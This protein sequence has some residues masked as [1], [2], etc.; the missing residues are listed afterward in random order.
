M[1]F[2]PISRREFFYSVGAGALAAYSPAQPAGESLWS[3]PVRGSW[4]RRGGS[5]NGDVLLA[6]PGSG[7][8][9]VVG[10]GEHTAVK[11][12]ASFLAADVKKIS[13]YTPP[14]VARAGGDRPAIYLTTLGAQRLPAGIQRTRLEGQWEAYQVLTS[15][16]DVWIVGSNFRGTAF[17]AYTLSERL[18]IDPLYHWTGYTPEKHLPLALKKTDFFAGPPT[19]KYRGLFHDDEDILPRPFDNDGYPLQTGTV[20]RVWYERYFETALRL[21]LNQVAPYTR[22]RRRFEVQ[23]MAGDWGL[24]YSSHHYDALLSN[25]FGFERFGL[26]AERKAGDRWDWY[27]NREGLENFW[28]GGVLENRDLD[29]IWPL[30]LRGTEDRSYTFPPGATE[31]ERLRVFQQVLDTQVRL[32]EQ[33]LPPG[34][35]PIFHFTVYGEMLN[36]YLSG[37]LKV[38]EQA[39]L[40]WTDN[41]DGTMRGLPAKA[42]AG[43]H[44]VYYHLA[45]YGGSTKQSAHTVTPERIA[46]EFRN[47]VRAGATE[48][49]LVNVSELRE[50]IMETRMIAE[51]CWNAS[52][53]LGGADPAARFVDWWCREYFGPAAAQAAEAYQRYYAV[54]DSYDKLWYG[55]MR[56]QEALTALEANFGGHSPAPIAATVR[57]ALARRV[58]LHREAAE[59]VA[60]AARAMNREQQQF[61][62]EHVALGL[63]F[64]RG[65]SEAASILLRALEAPDREAAWKLCLEARTPLEQ[66]EVDILR[67]ERPPFDGWYR[68]TWI[69][70]KDSWYNVHR[71][72]QHL[73]AFLASG[74]LRDSEDI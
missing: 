43:K 62:F 58:A 52:A 63:A 14:I 59:A 67:A 1:Y 23:K 15:G 68:P 16:R 9:I 64:D 33:L 7:C 61:F 44:G 25:P 4:V 50:F 29:C 5:E 19:F 35:T 54:M 46:G 49:V 42:S 66:L 47:I 71:S 28:R 18:G 3:A 41:G 21:R 8:E 20:P 53:A 27:A 72:Y 57:E 11:Q 40:V 65:P 34:K 24:F 31:E 12:A 10:D 55:A 48:Y 38:P 2:H 51:L 45:F 74:G 30:S 6:G 17:G 32:V 73:R 39:I 60:A 13:D 56:A 37:K 22:V 69:R 36:Y 26:A 70:K